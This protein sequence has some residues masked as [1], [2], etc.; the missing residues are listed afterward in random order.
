VICP[1][2]P[3][4]ISYLLTAQDRIQSI[5]SLCGVHCSIQWSTE[6]VSD[7]FAV[8]FSL[9]PVLRTYLRYIRH[10]WNCVSQSHL[11]GV[12]R[13]PLLSLQTKALFQHSTVG[14]EGS[15]TRTRQTMLG[16]HDTWSLQNWM[17]YLR[18]R[19]WVF[20]YRCARSVN[21]RVLGSSRSSRWSTS[22]QGRCL[23]T[24]VSG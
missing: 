5:L 4:L 15:Q 7:C 10:I 2:V 9:L 3:K 23:P 17:L 20:N 8:P 14:I 13:L 18:V 19:V 6:A 12:I 24:S 21:S 1:S 16:L 22:I 11:V